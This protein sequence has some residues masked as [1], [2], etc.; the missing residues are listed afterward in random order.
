[1]SIGDS[2]RHLVPAG[3][4]ESFVHE[5]NPCGWELVMRCC[6]ETQVDL[7]FYEGLVLL[8]VMLQCG[9]SQPV[10]PVI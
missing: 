10:S 3:A 7:L 8:G 6:F 1:M 9:D 4:K 5:F 2:V